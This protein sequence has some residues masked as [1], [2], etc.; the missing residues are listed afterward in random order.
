MNTARGMRH[1]FRRAGRYATYSCGF[2]REFV[3]WPGMGRG[4]TNELAGTIYRDVALIGAVGKCVPQNTGV[5][6]NRPKKL[7]FLRWSHHSSHDFAIKLQRSGLHRWKSLLLERQ[8][9]PHALRP[10]TST[11]GTRRRQRRHT[12]R[13]QNCVVLDRLW[14]V[15]HQSVYLRCMCH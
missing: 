13:R 7:N 11:S 12:S 1:A 2:L 8:S 6:R 10:N 15:Q 3:A 9:T 4:S 5:N 14:C